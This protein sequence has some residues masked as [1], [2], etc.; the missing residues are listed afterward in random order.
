MAR[1]FTLITR[2]LKSPFKIVALG[3]MV[4]ILVLVILEL[5]NTTHLFHKAKVPTVIPATN[6]TSNT[7][8]ASGQSAAN[9]PSATASGGTKDQ[10]AGGNT[11]PSSTSSLIAP[12]GS[13]VS[14]HQPGTNN[15]SLQEQSYC[16]TTPSAIC[17]IKFTNGQ[18]TTQLP[19]QTVNSQG[20]TSWSWNINDAHLTSGQWQITAVATLNGQ[21]KST[22]DQIKL[23]VQ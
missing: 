12:Y 5:T 10:A 6:Q 2:I 4:L 18:T 23:V 22:D 16:Y 13:F 1:R 19:S 8:Q 17:Y 3:I 15:S 11:A 9:Q 7:S 14:N 21:T 20:F